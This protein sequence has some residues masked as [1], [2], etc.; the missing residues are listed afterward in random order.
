MTTDKT[1][2]DRVIADFVE[3]QRQQLKGRSYLTYRKKIL[4]LQEY[5]IAHKTADDTNFYSILKDLD[6]EDI[7]DSIRFYVRKSKIRF[8]ATVDN[9]ISVLVAFFEFIR[10]TY[11]WENALFKDDQKKTH[12]NEAYDRLV[13]DELKLNERERVLPPS[14][15]EVDELVC[16]C[17]QMI[18]NVT[19]ESVLGGQYNGIYAKYISSL[20]VKLTLLFGCKN[21]VIDNLP[22]QAY[23][24]RI[25]RI[26]ING[27][28]V[29]LPDTLALQ[30][31]Q[32]VTKVRPELVEQYPNDRL[33]VGFNIDTH[34]DNSQKYAILKQALNHT[35]GT[36]IAKYAIMQMIRERVPSPLIMEFTGCSDT[37]YQ[38]CNELVEDESEI[39]R[40]T[41]KSKFL[42]Q[43]FR[44]TDLFDKL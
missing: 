26:T 29:H 8:K 16:L 11:E 3:I 6:E 24:Q 42:D 13:R 20:I 14:D 44:G 23:D 40:Q 2:F 35:Q 19:P 10:N 7:L 21:Q 34:V 38:H 41:D 25:H 37:I 1:T 17:N 39:T 27:Y 15:S 31:R 33:F 5:M 18:D 9:Y 43:A 4:V 32:Y 28:R 36:A 30:M 22:L 12:L